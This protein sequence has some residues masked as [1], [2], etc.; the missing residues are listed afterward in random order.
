MRQEG[1][2]Y[3]GLAIAVGLLLAG[4]RTANVHNV[5]RT[6]FATPARPSMTEVGEAIWAAGRREGW[7]VREIAPG[8]IH[9]EKHLR[10]HRALVRIGYDTQ[11]FDIT[12]L[13]ADALQYDGRHIHK[14]YNEWVAQ[15]EKAIQDEV[16]FRFR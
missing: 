13:E 12:L 2:R 1:A 15:L 5:A 4:C 10:A 9:A 16:R 7:R 3:I 14:A 11:S 8:D 6:A